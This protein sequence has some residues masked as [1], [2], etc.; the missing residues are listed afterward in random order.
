MSEVPEDL[1]YT[2]E[3]EW[4]RTDGG[5]LVVGITDYAQDQL[6]D[7]V[8]VHLPEVGA[9]VTAGEPM[10]EVESTK[11]VSDIYSPVSGKVVARND[12]LDGNPELVNEDPYGR[13]WLV[14]VEPKD[15]GGAELMDP[16]AYRKLVEEA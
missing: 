3:H 1:R 11:S 7:V 2:S 13:G 10:G 12:D 15:E 5:H 4:A 9:E 6:G 16:D 8:F 14:K